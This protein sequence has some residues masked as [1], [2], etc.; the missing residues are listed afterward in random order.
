MTPDIAILRARVSCPV[1]VPTDEGFLAAVTGFNLGA[2]YAPDAAVAVET[3]ADIVEAVRFAGENDLLVAVQNTGHGANGAMHGGLLILTGALD[4]MTIDGGTATIGAGAR[5]SSVVAAASQYGLTPIAGASPT[6]GV[7]GYL[8]GGG[9]GPLARSHGFSS[10]YVRSFRIVTGAGDLVTASPTDHADL[11]WALRGGKAGFGVVTSVDVELVALAE[12][13][14]GSLFFATEHIERALRG[15]IEWTHTADPDVSTSIAIIRFPPLDAVPEPM[16]GKTLLNLRFAYP[17]TNEDG[18]R[19]AAPLRALAPV[20]MDM[21]GAMPTTKMGMIHNDPTDPSPGWV[22]GR[23]FAR[24]DD[25]LATAL[26]ESVGPEVAAPFAA[27]EIRHLG[28]AT[29]VDVDGGSAVGGRE[30]AFTLNV[31]A[32]PNPGA[33]IPAIEAF[34]QAFSAAISPWLSPV[35]T[36]NFAGEPAA[37]DLKNSWSPAIFA[38]IQE[39]QR[40]YDPAGSFAWGRKAG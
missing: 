34:W 31:A 18:E 3:E 27:T 37:A 22:I 2:T 16:R 29:A 19:L 4:A 6:V 33:T 8:L 10:D 7:V 21:I 38:R 35:T 23:M 36:I 13:Y 12:I 30:G 40:A 32:V 25:A 11:F 1:F 9:L 15:W 17:G 5:W 20:M 26:I 24:A 14:G 28:S 39:V